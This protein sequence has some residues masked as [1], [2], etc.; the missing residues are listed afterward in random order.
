MTRDESYFQPY[1]LRN[2]SVSDFCSS[3]LY[4]YLTLKVPLVVFSL[5]VWLV[6]WISANAVQ[7][8]LVS[9]IRIS[10][11]SKFSPS[12]LKLY[13][14]PTSRFSEI[15]WRNIIFIFILNPIGCTLTD[16]QVLCECGRIVELDRKLEE[17]GLEAKSNE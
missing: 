5:R 8:F 16:Y 9:H 4:K 7:S 15:S 12:F 3:G 11:A 13:S 1:I 10:S 2:I 14:L 6:I 17:L